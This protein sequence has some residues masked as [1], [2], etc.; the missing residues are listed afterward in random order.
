MQRFRS[1]GYVLAVVMLGA[2]LAGCASSASYDPVQ[3]ATSSN[4]TGAEEVFSRTEVE[5]D[6]FKGMIN[7]EAP[8]V[9]VVKGRDDMTF[10]SFYLL[11]AT[12]IVANDSVAPESMQLYIS[13][14]YNDFGLGW[15]FLHSAYSDGVALDFTKI[16]TDVRVLGGANN[17]ARGCG[18][19]ANHGES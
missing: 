19:T 11:R 10:G 4:P 1:S 8:K 12:D 18:D 5:N 16:T 13:V 3:S 7:Y 17:I 9:S 15:A 6:T 14:N 2:T